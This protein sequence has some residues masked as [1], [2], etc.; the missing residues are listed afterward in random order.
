[1]GTK[2]TRAE[3][4]RIFT[5]IKRIVQKGRNYYREYFDYVDELIRDNKYSLWSECM[6]INF[7]I[8]VDDYTN[9]ASSKDDTWNK[10]LQVVESRFF[11]NL[12]EIHKKK[13]VYQIG[14]EIRQ[15]SYLKTE[16]EL[17][18]TL[19]STYSI[20]G[21]SSKISF[22]TDS[23]GI[24]MGIEV[25]NIS[26][27]RISAATWATYSQTPTNLREIQNVSAGSYLE[28]NS[29]TG[30]V[31]ATNS[32]YVDDFDA[33]AINII[34][35][36]LDID[37]PVIGD[38][39]INLKSAN[40]SVINVKSS[41]WT[42]GNKMN[43]KGIKFTTSTNYPKLTDIVLDDLDGTFQMDKVGGIGTQSYISNVNRVSGLLDGGHSGEWE[44]SI[45]SGGT[46]SWSLNS[47]MLNLSTTRWSEYLTESTIS[48]Q[49]PPLSGGTYHIEVETRN[50]Y[51]KFYH[52]L[53]VSRDDLLGTIK[54]VGIS[55]I[56]GTSYYYRERDIAEFYG[57][58]RTYLEVKK[59]TD[60]DP[61][62]IMYEDLSISE[63]ANLLVRYDK[64]ID[65]LLS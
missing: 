6:L 35:L 56:L 30:S 5:K 31:S 34:D 37:Y 50:P 61:I 63:E 19:T 40:G 12:K 59:T 49:I 57:M 62:T 18:P 36:D 24:K 38:L 52:R 64:A 4:F 22:S 9:I 7:S 3:I 16:L 26:K 51:G 41:S 25:G 60:A 58:D 44:L 29:F 13:G 11:G 47:W 10:M 39:D 55:D 17:S 14:E 27:V 42:K 8:N 46:Y 53:G 33:S 21:T 15:D 2:E 32:A 45:S 65:Y 20:A 28:T 54:E 43:Y 23:S 48:T 1:M